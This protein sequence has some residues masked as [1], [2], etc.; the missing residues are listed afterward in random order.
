MI[1]I[2]IADDH[3][4]IREGLKKTLKNESGMVVVGEAT[5][6]EEVLQHVACDKPEII[7]LDVS[8]PGK[9][10]LEILEE[11]KRVAPEC[12]I[13]ILSMYPEDRFAVRALKSG[14]SGYLT[15]ESTVENLVH[16]IRV[17]CGGE[18]YIT[19]SI[20]DQLVTEVVN[21]QGCAP[22]EKLSNRELEV[23]LLLARGI[24]IRAI[25][26]ELALSCS[27]VHTYRVR[28]MEKM[29]CQTVTELTRYALEHHLID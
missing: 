12:G 1:R 18:K 2:L 19:P 13:L 29:K 22:H 5:N 4:L 3:P 8:M 10:G 9:S 16:A 24:K 11:V 20:A 15:K 27:T 17:I 14:A 7:L 26:E 28:L 21:Q 25:A 6:A 23:M